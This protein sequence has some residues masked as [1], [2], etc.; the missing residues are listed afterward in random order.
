MLKVGVVAAAIMMLVPLA[1]QAG[2][3]GTGGTTG[4]D[5]TYAAPGP[6]AVVVDNTAADE[7]AESGA[8]PGGGEF[9]TMSLNYDTP[10]VGV[11]NTTSG[12]MACY[13]GWDAFKQRNR[14]AVGDGYGRYTTSGRVATADA[15]HDT[16]DCGQ[17]VYAGSIAYGEAIEL[18]ITNAYHIDD[19]TTDGGRT[20]YR[21]RLTEACDGGCGGTCTNFTDLSDAAYCNSTVTMQTWRQAVDIEGDSD[22]CHAPDITLTTATNGWYPPSGGNDWGWK[23]YVET[24]VCNSD[25]L[26]CTYTSDYGCVSLNFQ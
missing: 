6:N 11:T 20:Y 16:G 5:A 1:A 24:W 18:F 3:P 21:L 17:D 9:V 23:Y 7:L 12:Y 2:K 13:V 22:P 8:A 26:Y 19:V 4:G 15:Y 10:V 14:I 25:G